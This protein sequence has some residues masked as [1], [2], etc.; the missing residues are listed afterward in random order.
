MARA[1][2]TNGK[3]LLPDVDHRS[4]WVRRFRDVM[5]L[6]VAALG[7]EEAI[8]ESEKALYD[9]RHASSLSLSK[10]SRSSQ[11]T[12]RRRWLS[13]RCTRGRPIPCAGCLSYRVSNGVRRIS[14]RHPL[15]EYL[16]RSRPTGDLSM[17]RWPH[18]PIDEALKDHHLLGAAL[19][20]TVSWA[21]WLAVLRAAFGLDL[22]KE[23]LRAF[24]RVS[25]DREPPTRRV[26][27][28]WAIA[29]RRSGK[30]RIA[31]ALAVYAACFVDHSRKL[32]PG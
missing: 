2:V 13:L 24:R 25:G 18:L 9:A 32:S 8:S 14:R 12:A 5:A 19:G 4:L 7:G 11:Q 30:S 15:H 21:T 6:H 29:G 22:N 31:A 26:R 1:R 16:A 23:Q 3:E 20:S 10:W 17:R 27:E 28:L